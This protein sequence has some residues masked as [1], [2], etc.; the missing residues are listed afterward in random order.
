[1]KNYFLALI[2]LV[3]I[4]LFAQIKPDGFSVGTITGKVLDFK[5]KHII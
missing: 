1:M 2:T 5:S 4:Q 3:N